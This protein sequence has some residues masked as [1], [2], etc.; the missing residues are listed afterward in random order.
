MTAATVHCCCLRS[1]LRRLNCLGRKCAD[2]AALSLNSNTEVT[3]H[4]SKFYSPRFL[5]P[6]V[7]S[8]LWRSVS[9]FFFLPTMP[10]FNLFSEVSAFSR[11]VICDA[12]TLNS[13]SKNWTWAAAGI[14]RPPTVCWTTDQFHL[15]Q[16]DCKCNFDLS[17]L[18][19]EVL[20][21]LLF[22]KTSRAST[23]L[24]KPDRI[25]SFFKQNFSHL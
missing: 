20:Q 22:W 1:R 9:L 8:P 17:S 11:P 4:G 6:A 16:H 25:W 2:C 14:Q 12:A 24:C 19:K 3:W 18:P 7:S 15:R 13:I 23:G 5:S 10:C 21:R